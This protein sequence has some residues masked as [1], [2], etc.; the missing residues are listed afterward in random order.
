MPQQN[1]NPTNSPPPSNG[2]VMEIRFVST[3]AAKVNIFY[4]LR[5]DYIMCI[6]YCVLCMRYVI[7]I[8]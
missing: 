4:V 6:L 5:R 3:V 2:Q 8:M 7:H 1:G